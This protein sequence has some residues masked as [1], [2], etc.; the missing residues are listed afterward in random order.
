MWS[1]KSQDWL[2]IWTACLLQTVLPLSLL[3]C[4][5]LVTALMLPKHVIFLLCWIV[6]PGLHHGPCQC[7]L[8][9]RFRSDHILR[10]IT[11]HERYSLMVSFDEPHFA[12]GHFYVLNKNKTFERNAN[13]MWECKKAGSRHVVHNAQEQKNKTKHGCSLFESFGEQILYCLFVYVLAGSDPE[14]SARRQQL[15]NWVEVGVA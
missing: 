6:S 13:N 12:E 4:P 9:D 2:E 10:L 11:R 7:A 1:W 15:E 14:L 5:A 3:A 8:R